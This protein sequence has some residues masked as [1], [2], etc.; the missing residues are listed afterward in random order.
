MR[1]LHSMTS[2]KTRKRREQRHLARQ[3]R[4]RELLRQ[5]FEPRPEQLS[6]RLADFWA[7]ALEARLQASSVLGQLVHSSAASPAWSPDP[8]APATSKTKPSKQQ[9]L[10]TLTSELQTPP[11]IQSQILWEEWLPLSQPCLQQWLEEKSHRYFS[12]EQALPLVALSK[13]DRTT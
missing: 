10:T 9:D 6:P 4:A 7:R 12:E 13:L 5:A 3:L 1:Y 8:W 11:S 2:P